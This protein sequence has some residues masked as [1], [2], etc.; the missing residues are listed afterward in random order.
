M[1]KKKERE[2]LRHL[3]RTKVIYIEKFQ[4]H[5]QFSDCSRRNLKVKK[6]PFLKGKKKEGIT[7]YLQTENYYGNL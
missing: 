5:I 7:S 3:I 1:V 2:K 4:C 6:A